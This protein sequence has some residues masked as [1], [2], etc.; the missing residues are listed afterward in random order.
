MGQNRKCS[1][2]VD[3][4]RFAPDSGL[5][6]DIAAGPLCAMS[7]HGRCKLLQKKKPPEGG[8]LNSNPM[9]VDQA[10]INAGLI[11]EI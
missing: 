5:K 9:I 8:P 10:A 1:L 2:R 7:R 6:A 4:V 3:R 11:I